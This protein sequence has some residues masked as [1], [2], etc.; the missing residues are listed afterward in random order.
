MRVNQKVIIKVIV[1][2][3]MVEMRPNGVGIQHLR[4]N[5]WIKSLKICCQSSIN[6]T[7]VGGMVRFEFKRPY[8]LQV[9]VQ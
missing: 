8:K 6:S 9:V 7:N 3:L 2:D 1:H 5:L 4:W